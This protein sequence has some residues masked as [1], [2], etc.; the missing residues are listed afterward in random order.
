M[1]LNIVLYSTVLK[2]SIDSSHKTEEEL[3]D[4][5]RIVLT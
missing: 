2:L 3:L 5:E 4:F 1:D